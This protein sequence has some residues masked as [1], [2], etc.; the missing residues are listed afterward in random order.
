VWLTGNENKADG[1]RPCGDK[2][3][4]PAEIDPIRT[5]S[6]QFCHV[7]N[8]VPCEC[9]PVP[10]APVEDEPRNGLEIKG[11]PECV[12]CKHDATLGIEEPC[13][14]CLRAGNAY[15]YTPSEIAP[16]PAATGWDAALM[17]DRSG[18]Q[19][20]LPPCSLCGKSKYPVEYGERNNPLPAGIWVYYDDG[21]RCWI[22]RKC[23]RKEGVYDTLEATHAQHKRETAQCADGLT[24]DGKIPNTTGGQDDN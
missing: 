16:G 4:T 8:R 20:T 12:A 17:A 21:T 2:A 1:N 22:C 23:S 9:P 6:T 5:G 18:D 15:L 24:K 10:D 13:L 11:Y 3:T 7:C 14:T 19:D